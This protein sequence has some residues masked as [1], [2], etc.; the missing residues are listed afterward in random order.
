VELKQYLE[1]SRRWLWLLILGT[2]VGAGSAFGAS[3]LQTPEYRATATVLI[4]EAPRLTADEFTGAISNDRLSGTFLELLT[5]RPVLEGVILRLGLNTTPGR[6]ADNLEVRLVDGTRLIRVH[7]EGPD[8]A[9]A[10]LIANTV[11]IVFQEYNQQQQASR[12]AESK[13]AL[14]AEIAEL[15]SLIAGTQ[16]RIEALGAPEDVVGQSQLERLQSE[17]SLL[18]QSRTGL[19]QSLENVRLAESQSLNNI[20]LIEPA[21]TPRIPIR[22]RTL[23]NT[24]LAAVVG[25]ML[26]AGIAFLIEYLDDTLKT[27][28]QITAALDL[29]VIGVVAKLTPQQLAAGPIAKLEPRAPTTEAFRGLRTN[30]Q[31][32]SVDRPL[33]RLLVTSVGP[34]EGKSTIVANLAI[35]MAQGGQRV[36]IVDADLRRPEQHHLHHQSN[37]HGLSEALI[38]EGLHL[39]GALQ[40]A[41]VDNLVLLTTG[42]IPPNPAE[43]L[44]SQKMA[45]LMDLVGAEAERVI[46]DSPP[47]SAVTDAVVLAGVADGVLLVIEAGKTRLGPALQV[48]EQLA[49]VGANVVGVVLNKVPVRR[50]GYYYSNY[51]YYYS[52][53]Y[54]ADQQPRRRGPLARLAR[55]LAGRRPER[56]AQAQVAPDED[57]AP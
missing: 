6:L 37:R 43:I 48:R 53:Y 28:D 54:A 3:Q 2:V 39:N 31:Y 51:Y 13:Q 57:Q 5:S 34:G 20:V 21:E 41:G 17:I 24:A 44:G 25:L 47:V 7:A 38:Q 55:R 40:P 22:P 30:L 11:P 26:A 19:L 56:A 52:G 23:Q 12:Y 36:A 15:D 45:G 18:R 46:I 14:L 10:A 1:L 50:D 33:R 49:R 8:P 9:Q 27:P 16:T 32:A 4:S 42:A 29:P 35:V